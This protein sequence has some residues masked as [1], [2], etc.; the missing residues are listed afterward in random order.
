M[1]LDD[2]G[3][4]DNETGLVWEKSPEIVE[5]LWSMATSYSYNKGLGGRKGW[6]L[7][8]IEELLTLVDPLM[9]D[10]SL[11]S[12]HPFSGNANFSFWSSTTDVI[13]TSF[14][15]VIAMYNGSVDLKD[16]EQCYVSN[17]P[18]VWCVRGGH[19]H[20]SY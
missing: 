6:R 3:V 19:G 10:P 8:T 12:G 5:T 20:D 16:K 14:A 11:P 15:R 1:V 17:C 7:P 9:A 2:A 13:T 4:L 18:S